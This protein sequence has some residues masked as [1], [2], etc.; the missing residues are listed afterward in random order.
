MQVVSWR[1]LLMASS[2]AAPKRSF[3]CINICASRCVLSKES[4]MPTKSPRMFISSSFNQLLMDCFPKKKPSHDASA[5]VTN[6]KQTIEAGFRFR[7]DFVLSRPSERVTAASRSSLDAWSLFAAS[8]LV[9]DPPIAVQD[10]VWRSSG[11]R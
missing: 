1:L 2:K 6:T 11:V 7:I 9:S 10:I 5:M 8:S 3:E 4:W